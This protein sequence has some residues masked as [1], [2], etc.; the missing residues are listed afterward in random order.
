VWIFFLWKRNGIGRQGTA[1]YSKAKIGANRA[2]TQPAWTG[3][4]TPRRLKR[5]I[6]SKSKKCCNILK[7]RD[8]WPK[9]IKYPNGKLLTV[10]SS[11]NITAFYFHIRR[12]NGSIGIPSKIR[13]WAKHI[14]WLLTVKRQENW[15]LAWRVCVCL[16]EKVCQ[17][18]SYERVDRFRWKLRCMLQLASNQ[19]PPL[20]S[21]IG[22][23]FSPNL[24][25]GM[26]FAIL[27][28]L[29]SRKPK[30]ISKNWEDLPDVTFQDLQIW[31]FTFFRYL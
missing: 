7:R 25:R 2:Q 31:F 20:T 11:Q 28:T 30:K 27:W 3:I 9:K 12:T 26:I 21:T 22:P 24:G 6:R 5:S 18:I 4:N 19:E 17:W 29:I 8:G 1:S 15:F 13:S 10:A 16:C 23:L 14:S